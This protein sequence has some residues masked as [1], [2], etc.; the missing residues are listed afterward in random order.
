[1]VYV[2]GFRQWAATLAVA[3]MIGWFATPAAH[4]QTCAPPARTLATMQPAE[5]AAHLSDYA[6]RYDAIGTALSRQT[7]KAIALGDSIVQR[8]P[9]AM[10]QAATGLPTL[11]AGIGKSGTQTLN[12][13]LHAENWSS[14]H[15]TLVV[16]LIGTNNVFGYGACPTY[17]GIRADIDLIHQMWPS[18]K[19]VAISVLP[20]GIDMSDGNAAIEQ[21]DDNLSQGASQGHY[22]YLAAHDAFAC[23]HQTPCSLVLSPNW[24]HPTLAG[25]QVLDSLLAKLLQSP[26]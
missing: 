11:D 20:R 4:A 12:Y 15:P 8:W 14:Q 13:L 23:A 1:M 7:F 10:L 17:W 26:S 18:A 21:I 25:Y 16:V 19:V 5:T 2:A 3:L 24:V 9:V 6:W 22:L